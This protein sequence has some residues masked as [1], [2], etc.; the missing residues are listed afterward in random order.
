MAFLEKVN[1]NKLT[2]TELDIFSY[3]VGQVEKIPY[4]R[5]RDIAKEAHVSSTSV[6]RFIQQIGFESFIDFRYYVKEYLKSEHSKTEITSSTVAD[7]IRMLS[8]DDFSP[9]I[10][11]QITFLAKKMIQADLIIFMGLGSSGAMAEYAGYKISNLNYPSIFLKNFQLPNIIR[12]NEKT[13]LLTFTVS[14]STREC[15]EL[16]SQVSQLNHLFKCCITQNKESNAAQQS[17][18]VISYKMH[19]RRKKVYLDLSNQL[20]VMI[21]IETLCDYLERHRNQTL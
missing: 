21:I 1:L 2:P 12:E 15:V 10:D 5:V 18:Y 20:P 11:Q 6:F 8:I 7:H 9:D 17:D 4:M 14:G 19:E 3:I 13:V 16:L